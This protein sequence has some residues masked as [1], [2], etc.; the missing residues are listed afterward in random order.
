[1]AINLPEGWFIGQDV[2]T[3][4][5]DKVYRMI[6]FQNGLTPE[7]K[8]FIVQGFE[9]TS[10]ADFESRALEKIKEIDENSK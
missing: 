7:S 1:M 10:N 4:F 2:N 3:Y 8:A 5:G 6:R 9:N